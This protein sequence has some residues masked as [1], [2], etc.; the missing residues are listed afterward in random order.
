[1]LPLSSGT[2]ARVAATT[3]GG[4][5]AIL[6]AACAI[7][8]IGCHWDWDLS[9]NDDSAPVQVDVEPLQ[10]SN[11]PAYEANVHGPPGPWCLALYASGAG[12][13]SAANIGGPVQS[14]CIPIS[15]D[16]AGVANFPFQLNSSSPNP[17]VFAAVANEPC[18][19]MVDAD[20]TS[21]GGSDAQAPD[22]APSA[23]VPLG[24]ASYCGVPSFDAYGVWPPSASLVVSDAG[25][26]ETAAS[27]SSDSG[28]PDAVQ[29]GPPVGAEG[30]AVAEGGVDP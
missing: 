12:I 29:D 9:S 7:G 22:A 27:G 5:L 6:A 13:V 18:N 2:L 24:L 17:V 30:D 21:A 23:T 14:L 28:A 3:K 25:V 20:A 16:D 26:A 1:M 4:S 8:A 19:P 15:M 10:T 11:P